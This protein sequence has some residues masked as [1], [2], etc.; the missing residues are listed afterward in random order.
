[1][2]SY[3]KK[4]AFVV[5]A[6]DGVSP[7][8]GESAMVARDINTFDVRGEMIAVPYRSADWIQDPEQIAGTHDQGGRFSTPSPYAG[9]ISSQPA[10]PHSTPAGATWLNLPYWQRG[11]L[12]GAGN[13]S[14][15]HGADKQHLPWYFEY[16]SKCM[17]KN[18]E[19]VDPAS[20]QHVSKFVTLDMGI[21]GI[22]P[23]L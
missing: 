14:T 9:T 12:L 23:S 21:L 17:P 15:V 6:C 2:A 16:G 5:G 1:M 20:D 8:T 13:S 3:P 19:L 7:G 4:Y 11:D 18:E 10:S 22:G